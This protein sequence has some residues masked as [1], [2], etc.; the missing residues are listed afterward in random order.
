MINPQR[1]LLEFS[2]IPAPAGGKAG[3]VKFSVR[4]AGKF[5]HEFVVVKTDLDPFMLPTKTNGSVDEDKVNGIDELEDIKAGTTA[6]LKVTLQ[7]GKYAL[8]C[9]VVDEED[10]KPEVHYKLG[11]RAAFTVR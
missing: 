3:K 6:T 2:V 9:N 8:I 5:V 4:N 1:G 10:G 11:M 7:P